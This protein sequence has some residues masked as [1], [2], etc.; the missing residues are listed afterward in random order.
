MHAIYFAAF[1]LKYYY[2]FMLRRLV[3]DTPKTFSADPK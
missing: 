3:S 2:T 1:S